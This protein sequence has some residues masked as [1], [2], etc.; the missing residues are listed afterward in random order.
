MEKEGKCRFG[1]RCKYRHPEDSLKMDE[2]MMKQCVH[3]R[4]SINFLAAAEDGDEDVT[5]K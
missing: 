4:G 3:N 1:N 2:S 5:K